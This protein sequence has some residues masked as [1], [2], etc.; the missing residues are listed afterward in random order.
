MW[1]GQFSPSHLTC[2][3]I[4]RGPVAQLR[5]MIGTSS[6]WM[7]VAAAAMSA[8]T[9]KVPVVS[10]VTCTIIGM[11][12]FASSRARLAPLTAAL[13]CSGSWQVSIR[14]ASAVPAISP[15]HW[16][17]SASSRSWYAMWPSE[18]SRVPG[19]TEPRTKRVRPSCAN[20]AIASRANSAARRLRAKALSPIPN[21]PRV[22]GE[23]PK[24][25]VAAIAS[26]PAAR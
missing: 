2:S 19:P 8:P 9:S 13:I 25:S 3:A 24:L 10:T 11:S 4:S 12:F 26:Q 15:A 23:P 16:I 1:P 7:I 22:I 18:G 5:P 6:A 17:A 20:S 14:I 21:S